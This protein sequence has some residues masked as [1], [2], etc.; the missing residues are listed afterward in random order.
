VLA[1]RYLTRLATLLLVRGI[2][3]QGVWEIAI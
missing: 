3:G 1:R 2:A